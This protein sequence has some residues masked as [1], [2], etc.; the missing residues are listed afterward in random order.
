MLNGRIYT[1]PD[2]RRLLGFSNS[3]LCAPSRALSSGSPSYEPG[4]SERR[5]SHITSLEFHAASDKLN[6]LAHSTSI[7]IL[8]PLPPRGT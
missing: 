4:G 2:S 5:D 3:R 1:S 6:P 8:R 7:S